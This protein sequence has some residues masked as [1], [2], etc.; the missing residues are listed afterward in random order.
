MSSPQA[1][2]ENNPV[3]DRPVA[4]A[5]ALPAGILA[6]ALLFALAVPFWTSLRGVA[7]P[8]VMD[9]ERPVLAALVAIAAFAG[10]TAIAI[11]V[12]RVVNAVVG[13][14]VLGCGVAILAMRT[15]AAHDFVYGGTSL[16][17]SAI[18][19]AVWG[20]L[21]AAASWAIYRFGGRLP[22]FPA[23]G[24]AEVDSPTGPSARRAWFAAVLA[25]VV[26]WFVLVTDTKGQAIGAVTLGAFAA[27]FLARSLAR[28]TQPVYLA[29]AVLAAFAAT[30]GYI[31]FS[32]RGDLSV[33]LIDGSFPRFLRVMPVD[34]AAGALVGSAMGFGFARSFVAPPEE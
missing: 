24:D 34:A 31:A 23:T 18:E 22:D 29:A 21:V 11:V 15:G 12:A 3:Q 13:T 7:G 25:V 16:A 8:T 20:V 33:G 28:G 32:I 26:A 10:S 1:V 19:T 14:F 4:R 17:H 9:S 27:G 30:L 6:S 2:T 5:L